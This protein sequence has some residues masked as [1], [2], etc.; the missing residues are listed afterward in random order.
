V[1]P[2]SG[3]LTSRI[4]VNPATVGLTWTNSSF[5]AS[6]APSA[7]VIQRS[8]GNNVFAT[9]ATVVGSFVTNYTDSSVVFRSAYT[10][11]VFSTNV[12]GNSA[13]TGTNTVVW[14]PAAIATLTAT[15]TATN[16]AVLN[17]V[18]PAANNG[19]GIRVE[20]SVSGA[21][22]AALANLATNVTTYTDTVVSAAQVISYR[23]F[24]TNT[25]GDS[26][27][28]PVATI[29]VPFVPPAPTNLVGVATGPTTVSLSWVNVATNA[30]SIRLLRA[31][32]TNGA[33]LLSTL[34][35]AVVTYTDTNA[36]ANTNYTYSLV[37]SNAIGMSAAVSVA[38]T[39][40]PLPPVPSAPTTV[41]A[42]LTN[43]NPVAVLVNWVNTATN[44]TS[45]QV[46]RSVNGGPYAA[47]ATITG[48]NVTSYVDGTAAVNSTNAY[49]V[50][51]VNLGG[52]SSYATSAAV[53][54]GIRFIQSA[55]STAV[56]SASSVTTPSLASSQT[57]GNLNI[58]V[59]G[60]KDATRSISSV[61]DSAG[62]TYVAAA[63][64]TT[65]TGLRQA[66]YYTKAKA[67]AGNAVTVTFG[68]GAATSPDVR[69]LEYSGVSLLD[70]SSGSSGTTQVASF[71]NT[72]ANTSSANELVFGSCIS[73]TTA[74]AGTGFTSRIVT[75]STVIEDKFL[76]TI[77]S[78]ALTA[79]T[80]GA[81]RFWVAQ[82]VTFR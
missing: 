28:S 14:P 3:G 40:P 21:A 66:I 26:L 16:R 56:A 70:R 20:R 5:N 50:R 52:G 2:V 22:Y 1:P 72:P 24:I 39:T 8:A 78:W 31:S 67:S 82:A 41:V 48:S 44:A 15:S 63:S 38:V 47:L 60:W 75:A 58:V 76:T 27:A 61:T 55:T 68:G 33:T 36:V 29:T 6:N 9:I 34:G 23:L 19:S 25:I 32:G 71:G 59:V 10:Y 49:Q 37:A 73:S 35:T 69:I 57:A 62:N 64:V 43:L 13:F 54:V 45:F 53:F 51:A 65:G 74:S 7:F 80:T 30:T 17:W 46:Q 42:T 81:S 77:G 4:S 79:N 11:R 12:F 18:N